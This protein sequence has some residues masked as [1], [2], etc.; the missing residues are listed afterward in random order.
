MGGRMGVTCQDVIDVIPKLQ[1]LRRNL[2]VDNVR[3]LL[4]TGS[5]TTIARL[6]RE[7]KA[8]QGLPAED[9]G[10]LPVELNEAVKSLWENMQRKADAQVTSERQAFEAKTKEVEQQLR[11]SH[12]LQREQQQKIHA[13]EEG[14]AT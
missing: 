13:L 9:D 11:Q 2:T 3:D 7:W 12:L 6:L 14:V 5:K 1:E 4:G 8:Q 10:R